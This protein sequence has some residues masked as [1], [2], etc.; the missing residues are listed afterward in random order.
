[1]PTSTTNESPASSTVASPPPVQA[2]ES[3]PS[4]SPTSRP[5]FGDT[6]PFATPDSAGFRTRVPSAWLGVSVIIALMTWTR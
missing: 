5:R 2:T 4:A 1:V 6:N 3:S